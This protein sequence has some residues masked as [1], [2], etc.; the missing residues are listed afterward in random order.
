MRNTIRSL[1]LATLLVYITAVHMPFL[2]EARYSL[3]AKP[4]VMLLATIATADILGRFRQ[5]PVSV[6]RT[7]TS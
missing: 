3:P 2:A 6:P 4:M 5:S 7:V 1:P